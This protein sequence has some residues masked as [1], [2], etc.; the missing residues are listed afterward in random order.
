[1]SSEERRSPA[2]TPAGTPATE[3][4]AAAEFAEYQANPAPP[5]A[6]SQPTPPPAED[7]PPTRPGMTLATYVRPLETIG[8]DGVLYEMR[9]CQDYT[10]GRQS[11][12]SRT[13]A[14]QLSLRMQEEAGVILDDEEAATQRFMLEALVRA[15]LPDLPADKIA[16]MASEEI[17]AIV[18]HFFDRSKELRDETR[19]R[20]SLRTSVA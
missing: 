2:A 9:F 11:F 8:I 17:E 13:R 16:A 7:A 15:A 5:S 4:E 12:L 1:M 18:G 3:A 20:A 10:V 6:P 14:T 19:A